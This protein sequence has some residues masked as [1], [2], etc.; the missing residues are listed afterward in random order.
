[1]SLA[2]AGRFLTTGPAEKSYLIGSKTHPFKVYSSMS[3]DTLHLCGA[4]QAAL[5][6]KNLPASAGDAGDLGLVPGLG[7]ALGVG[8]ATYSSILA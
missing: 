8:N 4:S 5:V 3:F 2:S 6:A 7:R 1:M